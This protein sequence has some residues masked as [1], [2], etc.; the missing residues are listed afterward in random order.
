MKDLLFDFERVN[1]MEYSFHLVENVQYTLFTFRNSVIIVRKINDSFDYDYR[2]FFTGKLLHLDHD[3]IAS[4]RGLYGLVRQLFD[5]DFLP[6]SSNV[7]RLHSNILQIA[8]RFS[9][10]D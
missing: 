6:S 5:V 7:Y 3:F 9:Y 4:K 2:N 1:D 8:K 10:A